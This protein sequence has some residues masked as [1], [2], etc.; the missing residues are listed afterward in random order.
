[1]NIHVFCHSLASDWNHGNAHFLRGICTQ[2]LARGHALTTHEQADAWSAWHLVKDHGEAALTA[3]LRAY[4]S[5][6]SVSRTYNY[7][8]TDSFADPDAADVEAAA[9]ALDLPTRIGDADLVLVHEWTPP[10][11]V[12]AVGAYR[13]KVG[14]FR[15]L[16][17]DT[18][19]RAVSEPEKMARFDLTHY[20]GVLAFGEVLRQAYLKQGWSAERVLTWHEAADVDVFKPGARKP[21]GDLVWVGNWGDDERTAELHEFLLRPSQAGGFSSLVHGVRYPDEA[22]QALAEH[23]L[24]FGGYLPNYEAPEVFASYYAT[25]HVPRKWYVTHLPGIP[26]IRVFEALACGIPLVS[27]PWRDAEGLFSPGKDFLVAQDGEDMLRQLRHLLDNADAAA[28]LAE[29]GRQTILDRHTC[30]HRVEELFAFVDG[31]AG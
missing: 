13:K 7:G 18:H 11:V 28:E 22:R 21:E 24:Q 27:A 9:E 19:H 1:V 15:L 6:Q 10:G 2:L 4:P 8:G 17:H 26:T 23:G 25:V 20:D 30:R 16:F 12:A 14:G 3:Y 31:V 29:R 5:L